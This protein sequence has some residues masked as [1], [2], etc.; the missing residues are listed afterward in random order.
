MP[1]AL[2]DRPCEPT[3]GDA[4]DYHYNCTYCGQFVIS[5]LARLGLSQQGQYRWA[6]SIATRRASDE[7]K[8]K[9]LTD[10]PSLIDAYR[11]TPFSAKRLAFLDRT[12]QETSYVG[13]PVLLVRIGHLLSLHNSTKRSAASA[14]SSGAKA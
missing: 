2:C 1:C 7:G 10:L 9:R 4:D 5:G 6:L 12:A 3:T 14:I 11:H 13:D 8:P